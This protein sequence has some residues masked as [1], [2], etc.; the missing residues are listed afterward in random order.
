VTA[1][2]RLDSGPLPLAHDLPW[3]RGTREALRRFVEG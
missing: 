3:I 2:P 1:T